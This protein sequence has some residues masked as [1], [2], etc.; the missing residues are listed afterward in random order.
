[1][2]MLLLEHH[3]VTFSE[4]DAAAYAPCLGPHRK[5]ISTAFL[6]KFSQTESNLKI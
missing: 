3:N 5:L 1:M 6:L 4:N 2:C